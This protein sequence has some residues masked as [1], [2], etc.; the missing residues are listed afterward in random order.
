MLE[1]VVLSGSLATLKMIIIDEDYVGA[2]GTI[3][4]AI[5]RL[6]R[7]HIDHHTHTIDPKEEDYWETDAANIN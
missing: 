6:H 1:R 2:A 3:H 4:A 5:E 7:I